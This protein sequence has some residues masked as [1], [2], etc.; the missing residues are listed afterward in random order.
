M[1]LKKRVSLSIMF[2]IKKILLKIFFKFFN[3]EKYK[4][5]KNT[6]KLK[7][8]KFL[9]KKKYEN[10]L[11]EIQENINKKKEI[12]FLHSGHTGDI[13]N[14]LPILKHLSETHVCKLYIQLDLPA[15]TYYPDHPA[16]QFLMNKKIYNMLYPLLKKQSYINSIEP[17]TNQDIDINFDLIRELPIQLAFDSMKYGCHISGVQPDL[18]QTFLNTEGHDKIKNKIIIQRSLRYQ[19][20]FINYDF[21]NKY[22]DIYFLG[23]FKEY[24]N[25]KQSIKNLKFYECKDFLEMAE[26]IKSC[27]LFIGN[28]SLGF[29]LAEGLKVPRLLEAS[30]WNP[31]QQVH[32]KNGFDFFFQPHFKNF[33]KF[34]YN[35]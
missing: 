1:T 13:I 4:N 17:F 22:D 5:I 32:G 29:T 21:L 3:K 16:G 23:T 18:T 19:N 33:F 25:L 12:S 28:S 27:K 31:S 7:A 24:E 30:P 8:D 34:L 11:Y 6:T 14:I 20:H 15:T 2:N 10:Y 9:F 35:K 26:I